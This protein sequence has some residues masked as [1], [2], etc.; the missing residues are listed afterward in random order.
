MEL[1]ELIKKHGLN[2]KIETMPKSRNRKRKSSN[3]KK[4]IFTSLANEV[5]KQIENDLKN[6]KT[7]G[8]KHQIISREEVSKDFENYFGSFKE[9]ECFLNCAK[10]ES[11]TAVYE[12]M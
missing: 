2:L 11:I 12:P 8:N 4:H 6:C 9:I 5:I 7:C 1:L 10:C 3:S